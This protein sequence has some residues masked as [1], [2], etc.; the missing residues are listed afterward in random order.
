M[1]P[2]AHG[3]C[4]GLGAA[5]VQVQ[6]ALKGAGKGGGSYFPLTGKHGN[7]ARHGTPAGLQSV[8][9]RRGRLCLHNWS[10]LHCRSTIPFAA[11]L[12]GVVG[13][14]VDQ[15][16]DQNRLWAVQFTRAESFC[17]HMQSPR[18]V[19]AGIENT[20]RRRC[21]L[22]LPP[23]PLP[24]LSPPPAC[25]RWDASSNEIENGIFLG[26]LAAL[27]FKGPYRLE[28]KVR[29]GGRA[30]AAERGRGCSLPT[31]ER[32]RGLCKGRRARPRARQR[33]VSQSRGVGAPLT[34]GVCDAPGPGPGVLHRRS[35]PLTL[36]R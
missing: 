13:L 29:C 35:W 19:L 11:C 7:P 5:L 3:R 34:S 14:S 24:C 16:V 12:L 32:Q 18:S 20:C 17:G 36:I 28:G 8:S 31:S 23:A 2:P 26:R 9:F 1:A 27:T 6:D 21:W 22:T 4:C 33:G 30:G 10:R 25:Q 15:T